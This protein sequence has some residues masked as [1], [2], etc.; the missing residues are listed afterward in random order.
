MWGKKN[1]YAANYQKLVVGGEFTEIVDGKEVTRSKPGID[2]SS[3]TNL[4][5]PDGLD[6]NKI[7]EERSQKF[8]QNQSTSATFGSR[9]LFNE[10]ILRNML[11]SG[12]VLT[13]ED[14]AK[15]RTMSAL[16]LGNIGITPE[17]QQFH[18]AAQNW[19]AAQLRNES[20][21]AIAASEYADAL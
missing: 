10:G 9:M 2:L 4:P 15:I 16:G 1:E 11:A 21:A 13:L 6:L 20:G 8:D 19:V 17:A 12:Y 3:T 14:V 5:I 18:V 7:I